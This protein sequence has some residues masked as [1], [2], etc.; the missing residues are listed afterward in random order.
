V[1]AR[2]TPEY[3]AMGLLD[4]ILLQGADSVLYKELIKKKAYAGDVNGGINLLGNMF[5]YAGPMLWMGSLIHE[6][7]SSADDILATMDAAIKQLRSRSSE[8]RNVE[9]LEDLIGYLEARRAYLPDYE[10][11]RRAG[12]WI[13]S[14]RV[15]K[16]LAPWGSA[17]SAS[18]T[19]HGL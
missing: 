5:N 6:P 10:A 14:N 8:M 1:P 18:S 13:A 12:L 9:V 15:E 17:V 16:G 2:N 11:R 3:Y 7:T 19:R 4:Q